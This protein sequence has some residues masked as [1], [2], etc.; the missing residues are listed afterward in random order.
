MSVSA[1]ENDPP[2][3]FVGGE[4]G[5]ELL[6]SARSTGY[7]HFYDHG[8]EEE[9]EYDSV[10]TVGACVYYSVC[11]LS[12]FYLEMA[13]DHKSLILKWCSELGSCSYWGSDLSVMFGSAA[14]LKSK[15]TLNFE[16]D[17]LDINTEFQG[18][19]GWCANF[20]DLIWILGMSLMA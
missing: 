4:D 12:L 20:A 7:E 10:C 8:E 9:E 14:H 11:S 2:R 15:Y 16:V 6:D 3:F 1:T 17:V 5:E 19:W 13:L 18:S